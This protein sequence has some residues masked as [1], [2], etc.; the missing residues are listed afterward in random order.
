MPHLPLVTRSTLAFLIGLFLTACATAPD[1]SPAATPTT[2]TPDA[3]P[4]VTPT[5]ISAPTVAVEPT[6]TAELTATA[7]TTP[8]VAAPV[9]D[10][11][12]VNLALHPI[13]T[14][15]DQPLFATHAGDGSGRLFVLEKPGRIRIVADGQLAAAPFLD[16]T[17]RVL[18]SG[19]EQGLLGLAFPPD[20]TTTG[21][22]FVNYTD[23]TGAT[24]VARF[25]TTTPDQADPNSEFVVLTFPQPARNHNGGM[26]AF[27]PDGYLWIGTG[28]GGAAGDRFGNGQ[29]PAT[30]LGKMLRL[31]VTSDPSVPYVVPADNPWVAADWNGQDVIDEAWALGLRNPWRFSF[32]RATDDLWIADVG[33]NQYEEVNFISAGSP[34]GLNFGWPILEA[35]HCYENASCDGEPPGPGTILPVLEYSHAGGHCSITGGYVYRGSQFPVLN[36]V[37]FYSDYCSGV[38]WA[39]TPDGDGWTATEVLQSGMSV[40]SFGEDETGEVYVLDLGGGLYQLAAE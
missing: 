4:T 16:L 15:L 32:D 31:D 35:T 37:Y 7:E 25:Q 30:L 6:T 39:A 22:F 34:G 3:L 10:P 38:I 8:A 33:Q 29:N 36:G 14:D 26:L 13:V 19:S 18:S 21:Y 23:A 17:D 28:D 27:G 40:A 12:T 5:V 9:F 2:V 20:F 24:V 1:T 11:A